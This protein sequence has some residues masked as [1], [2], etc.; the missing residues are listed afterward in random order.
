MEF[1][2]EQRSHRKS[3]SFQS[4][5]IWM[6]ILHDDF[7]GCLTENSSPLRGRNNSVSSWH[8]PDE[9][10]LWHLLEA[11][12]KGDCLNDFVSTTFWTFFASKVAAGCIDGMNSMALPPRLHVNFDPLINRSRTQ[13]PKAKRARRNV[14]VDAKMK[15]VTPLPFPSLPSSS[16]RVNFSVTASE[17][18]L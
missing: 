5:Q 12:Q 1:A 15:Q 13:T 8:N 2:D 11:L 17:S 6:Q 18:G 14:S 4:P 10:D 16:S 3:Y 7:S 9:M